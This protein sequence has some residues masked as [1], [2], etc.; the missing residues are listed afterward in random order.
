MKMKVMYQS[1]SGNTRKIAEAIAQSVG[2]VAEAMPPAYPPENVKLLFMGCGIY[3]GKLD[4]KVTDYINTLN[5]K[6]VQNVA[7]F[8]TTGAGQKQAVELMKKQL[9]QRGV[10]V[11]SECFDCKGKF[12]GFFNRSKPGGDE[13][14]AAQEFA[15]K[16]MALVKE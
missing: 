14:K 16:A 12:F 13:L 3:G 5:T 7:L 11:L 2:E 9:E 10:N 6:R 4:K 15:T 1:K 8:S